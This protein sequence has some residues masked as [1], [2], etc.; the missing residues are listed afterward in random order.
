[1]YELVLEMS[2]LEGNKGARYVQM[3]QVG[4]TRAEEKKFDS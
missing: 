3:V 2:G 4:S 1:V